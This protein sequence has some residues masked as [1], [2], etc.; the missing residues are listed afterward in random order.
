MSLPGTQTTVTNWTGV[1]YGIV[2]GFVA[3]YFQFKVP[4]VLPVLLD[5]YSYDKFVAG[6]F[7]SIFAV[8]GMA[9]SVRVGRS[10]RAHGAARYLAG[11]FFLLIAGSLLGL[12]VPESGALMLVARTIEGLG[13]AVLAVCMP[14]FANMNA[15]P[16]HLPVIIAVQATWIPVGQVSANLIAQPAVA[17]GQWQP[18]WWAGIIAIIAVAVWTLAIARRDRIQFGGRSNPAQEAGR[19]GETTQSERRALLYAAVLFFLSQAQF[20]AYF[21]W[22]PVYLVDVRGFSADGAVLVNQ[23]PVV[24]L[25]VFALATGFVLRA[26]V[27]A[28]PLLITALSLQAASWLLIPVAGSVVIGT[29]SLVAWG[30]AAGITPTCLWALP[31]VLLGGHRADTHAFAVVLTGRYLGILAGPLIAVAIFRLTGDW[32]SVAY[33]FGA[34]TAFCAAV[35]FYLGSLVKRI[36]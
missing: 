29:I 11:A 7:M 19:I 31:S 1:S 30:I 2:L 9:I 26:G 4:P 13:A 18:V 22:L 36:D 32:L 20:M 6:G 35:A 16:R 17:A 34:I 8:A 27:G 12:A 21:T 23:I 5:D 10:I 15:G 24:V 33:T 25:L 28:I 14:A 3:A